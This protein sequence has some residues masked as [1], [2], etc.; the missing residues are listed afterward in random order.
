MRNALFFIGLILIF[1]CKEPKNIKVSKS[2]D[3]F[4]DLVD[5]EGNSFDTASVKGKKILINF[6]ATWCAPCKNEMPSLQ[7]LK[8]LLK[9]ENFLFLLISDESTA[10]ILDF[11]KKTKY[12]FTFLKSTKTA[13]SLGVYALPTT[14]IFNEEGEK[15]DEI[16][17]AVEWNSE[18]MIQKL[19]N[20][21]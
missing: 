17:G 3:V 11:K 13:A 14:F 19:K 8:K 2:F 21:K 6:W 7:E 16:I 12:D 9:K 15:V 18:K 10:Q 1:S 4:N 5:L 20:I